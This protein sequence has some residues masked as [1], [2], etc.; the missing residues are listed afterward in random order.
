[1]G[2]GES[3]GRRPV[4]AVSL[5]LAA[6]AWGVAANLS[7][8]AAA[9]GSPADDPQRMTPVEG[10]DPAAMKRGAEIYATV[11]SACHEQGL[12]RAPERGML[13]FMSA[14]S[15]HEALTHG[16]MKVQGS[17]LSDTDK[18]AVAEFLAGRPMGEVA[19]PP[20]A[21]E[22]GASRF[23]VN[24]TPPFS[25][26]GLTPESTHAIPTREAGIDRSNVGRLK[27]KWAF[28]Y[29][30]A[31]RARSQPTI[32]GGAIFV[33][34][35]DG[36]VFALDRRTGCARWTYRA[37][38][39]VRT[40]VVLSSWRAGDA[41][42]RPVVYFGDLIGN[43]YALDAR[44][45]GLIWRRK[46]DDHTS[47]T[48]TGTPVLYG[49]RLFAPLSSL[50]E[51][52]ATDPTYACC[53]FRGSMVSLDAASGKI[54]WRTYMVDPP[55][56]RGVTAGGVKRFGPSGVALWNSPA[57][58]VKRGRLYFG[59]GDNYSAPPSPY[60]DAVMALD[61]KTGRIVWTYQALGGDAWNVAC[62][63][64]DKANC[65][66]GAGP[67]YDFGAGVV[68]AHAEG[69]DYVLAGQKAGVVH[70]VDPDTG[71]LLWKTKVGR[72]GTLGGVHFGLAAAG[73]T[74]FVPV[75]DRPDGAAHSQPARPG[76][77][78]LDI[79]TGEYR[80]KAPSADVCAAR[81]RCHPGYAAAIT[82]TPQL[83]LAGAS[84]GHL[85]IY[86]AISGKV[87]WDYDTVRSFTTVN[88]DTAQGGG[89]GG[90][91]APLAYEGELIANSGYGLG[92]DLPG[93]ALLVFE[94]K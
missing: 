14:P 76:L 33:G 69:R 35:H 7:N 67:D 17:G 45:G 91:T 29:P 31:I 23:D 8:A 51:G 22:P 15:I 93:A 84:D 70:A 71:R 9:G 43:L 20:L 16:A 39:E 37:A 13:E 79:R 66:S 59:T 25:G 46:P 11:C 40:G 32:G 83:V 77:Y 62:S 55:A 92:G 48:I 34:S 82:A 72:G 85:R 47:A 86:D 36:T 3:I 41:S 75:S 78:A 56:P 4:L 2:W 12:N 50:E 49:G 27:L 52:T 65:P 44:K 19:K 63:A 10:V 60:S 24:E 30:N 74:V 61:L 64:A 26:W 58:D 89:M 1:M 80:W 5:S 53:T 81:P 54:L 42:A 73:D 21:C 38:S 87:L 88:G 6:G 68:L 57:I 18:R 90:G 94:A 28:A